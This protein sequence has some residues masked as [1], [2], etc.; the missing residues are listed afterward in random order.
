MGDTKKKS[1]KKKPP[2]RVLKKCMEKK[3]PR[4]FLKKCM[5]NKKPEATPLTLQQKLNLLYAKF[6]LKLDEAQKKKMQPLA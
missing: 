2:R 6:Q 4:R 5:K 1:R 3:P